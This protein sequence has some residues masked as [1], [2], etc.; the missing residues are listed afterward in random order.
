[1]ANIVSVKKFSNNI[2]VKFNANKNNGEC[3]GCEHVKDKNCP[4]DCQIIRKKLTTKI[5]K[6]GKYGT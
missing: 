3:L 5:K 2:V 6:E 1:M 4:L